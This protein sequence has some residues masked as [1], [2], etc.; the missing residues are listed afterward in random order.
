ML[1]VSQADNILF[2][3]ADA[4]YL[5]KLVANRTEEVKEK[6]IEIGSFPDENTDNRR[7][8]PGNSLDEP[9]IRFSFCNAF[10]FKSVMFLGMSCIMIGAWAWFVNGQYSGH[11]FNLKYPDCVVPIPYDIEDGICDNYEPYNTEACGWDGGDCI[12]RNQLPPNEPIEVFRGYSVLEPFR[13]GNGFCDVSLPYFTEECKWGMGKIVLPTD[14]LTAISGIPKASVMEL[15]STGRHTIPLFVD[16]TEVIALHRLIGPSVNL[17]CSVPSPAFIGNERCD[18]FSPYSTPECAFDGGDCPVPQ[19]IEGLP[20][21]VVSY[22]EKL[23][24]GNCDQVLPYNS[25]V[26][27]RDGGDCIVEGYPECYVRYPSAIGDD[28][29]DSYPPYNTLECG[30]DGGDCYA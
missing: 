5:G 20:G 23:G 14:I 25:L 2:F 10:V 18:D 30:Y 13:I 9:V 6:R 28:E 17:T 22:P 24:D 26:C 16:S 27:N 29:C 7:D 21:C 3:L 8:A 4:G 19:E 1:V 11:F 15:V 12:D